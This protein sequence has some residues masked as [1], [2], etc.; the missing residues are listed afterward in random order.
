MPFGIL[1]APKN[2]ELATKS[3]TILYEINPK[4]E[5][6]KIV[7]VFLQHPTSATVINH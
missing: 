4:T 7:D 2:A 5:V 3:A 6:Y 1:A